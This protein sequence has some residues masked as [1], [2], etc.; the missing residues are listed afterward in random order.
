MMYT[1][2]NN[3]CVGWCNRAKYCK[4]YLTRSLLFIN[5]RLTF[6]IATKHNL[7]YTHAATQENSYFETEG[8][9]QEKL[10]DEKTNTPNQQMLEKNY[11]TNNIEDLWDEL[12]GMQQVETQNNAEVSMKFS[13]KTNVCVIKMWWHL[14]FLY[15]SFCYS[16][17]Y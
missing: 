2:Y 8:V 4:C 14:I 15:I 7:D 11:N 9:K 17:S 10:Q 6:S 16:G 12:N 3:Y 5:V 13:A 1:Y